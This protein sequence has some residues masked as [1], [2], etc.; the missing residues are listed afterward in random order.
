MQIAAVSLF[1]SSSAHLRSNGDLEGPECSNC[2]KSSGRSISLVATLLNQQSAQL[3]KVKELIIRSI[4]A[5]QP[6]RSLRAHQH[7]SDQIK[8]LKE[9]SAKNTTGAVS[10]CFLC[11]T[12]WLVF[13]K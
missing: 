12:D 7:S 11:F 3:D 1:G 4:C 13:E 8:I 10:Y 5:Q 2:Y 9:K 6:F